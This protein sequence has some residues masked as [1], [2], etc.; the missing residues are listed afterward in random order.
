MSWKEQA[1]CQDKPPEWWVSGPV[2]VVDQRAAEV[3]AVCPVRAECETAGIG[4]AGVYGGVSELARNGATRASRGL[5]NRQRVSCYSCGL[6]HVH[7]PGG[8]AL[9]EMCRGDHGRVSSA[10]RSRRYRAGVR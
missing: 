10:A 5:V 7:T 9:C 8:S 6:P 2:D 1:A 4:E 3:C